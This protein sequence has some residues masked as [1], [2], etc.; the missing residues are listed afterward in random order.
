MIVELHP[1]KRLGSSEEIAKAFL[2]LASEDSSFVTGTSLEV[3]GG[4]LAR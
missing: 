3:D 4:Y 2:F 1:M